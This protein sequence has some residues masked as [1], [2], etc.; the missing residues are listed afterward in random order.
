VAL[1]DHAHQGQANGVL[2][3]LDDLRHVLDGCVE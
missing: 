2:F 3:A 1:G